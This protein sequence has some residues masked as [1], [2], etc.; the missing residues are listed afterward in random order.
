MPT[1]L[2]GSLG[3][4]PGG[5]NVRYF[6]G[7]HARC[8]VRGLGRAG[9]SFYFDHPPEERTAWFSSATR[10]EPAPPPHAKPAAA[11]SFHHTWFS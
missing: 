6:G 4:P 9:Q 3:L 10:A 11:R 1:A 7:M 8:P 2:P 5:K